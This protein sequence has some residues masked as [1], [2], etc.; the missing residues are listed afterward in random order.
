MAAAPE[1]LGDCWAKLT[2]W[3]TGTIN[4]DRPGPPTA[5]RAWAE[6]FE[7]AVRRLLGYSAAMGRPLELAEALADGPLILEFVFF[8]IEHRRGQRP[9]RGG[10]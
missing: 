6:R 4:L 3:S 2:A 9:R 1:A 10:L 8:L 7:G 5:I